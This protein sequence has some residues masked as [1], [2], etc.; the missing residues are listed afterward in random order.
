MTS[1]DKVRLQSLRDGIAAVRAHRDLVRSQRA[2]AETVIA[3]SR[4]KADLNQKG[5]EVIKK[6]LEDLLR[7]NVGSIADLVTTALR[8]IIFDQQLTFR[9]IQEPKYNR[10]AMRFV[11]EENGVEADPMSSFGGGA[12]VVASFVLRVAI[13]SRLKMS[14]LLL[15]DESMFALANRYVPACADFMGQLS[16]ETGVAIFMVTHNDEFMANASTAYEGFVEPGDDGLKAL[17]LR[18]RA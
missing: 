2:S 11:I 3:G 10:L 13:M 6:W 8:H 1:A 15:L 18:R 5:S 4:Y 7:T 12:A 16:Q 17:R 14:N 9:I